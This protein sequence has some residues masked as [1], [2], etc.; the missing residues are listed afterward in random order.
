MAQTAYERRAV[1]VELATQALGREGGCRVI[2]GLYLRTDGQYLA[3]IQDDASGATLVVGSRVKP[4]AAGYPEL[5]DWRR[6]AISAGEML[7]TGL[8]LDSGPTD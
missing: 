6:L 4:R 3:L 2:E 5:S 8:L 7:Q 1:I